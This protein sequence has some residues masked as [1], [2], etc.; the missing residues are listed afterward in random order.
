MVEL[1]RRSSAYR[2]VALSVRLRYIRDLM[3]RQAFDY[4]YVV[5]IV[6]GSHVAQA[7]DYCYVVGTSCRVALM[8][9][10]I[11]TWST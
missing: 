9:D 8:V 10:V 4:C 3:S 2:Y 6:T 5:D 7:F 1:V 11:S